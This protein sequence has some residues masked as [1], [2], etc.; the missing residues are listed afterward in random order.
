VRN[1][2]LVRR[3]PAYLVFLFVDFFFLFL[4]VRRRHRQKVA[5]LLK[6]QMVALSMTA[7]ND[8]DGNLRANINSPD[9]RWVEWMKCL[10]SSLNY[11]NWSRLG[12]D[13][14]DP[15]RHYETC[16]AEERGGTFFC[17]CSRRGEDFILSVV[18]FGF[19]RRLYF[20][21]WPPIRLKLPPTVCHA[22]P[23]YH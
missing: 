23:R 22:V 16:G 21:G 19:L 14:A 13:L 18:L 9:W 3:L 10:D 7:I 12:P 8:D 4:L 17:F 2:L 11:F 1:G 20:T 5:K 15:M 6:S